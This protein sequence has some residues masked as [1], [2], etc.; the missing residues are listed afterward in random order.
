M[1]TFFFYGTLMDADV[2]AAVLG[3]LRDDALVSPA[4]L[5]GWERV[6]LRG[7]SYPVVRPAGAGIVD[8]LAVSFAA[9]STRQIRDLL[10]S[11]E[12]PEYRMETLTLASGEA[13]GVFVASRR[14]HPTG[15]PWSFADWERR[16]KRAFL[17][18]IRR[19][20]EI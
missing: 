11:F 5:A 3:P 9:G 10:T 20:R 8:G 12:G 14:C 6:G 7:R 17:A 16:H 18:A 19:G 2:R 4:R 1:S 15:R 13:A